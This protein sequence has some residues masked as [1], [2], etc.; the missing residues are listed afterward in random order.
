LN[1]VMAQTGLGEPP[2]PVK[3]IEKSTGA[4]NHPAQERIANRLDIT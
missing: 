3:I 4:N 2:H 1:A